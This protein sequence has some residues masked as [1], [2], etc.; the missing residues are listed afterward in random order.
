KRMRSDMNRSQGRKTERSRSLLSSSVRAISSVASTLRSAGASIASTVSVSEDDRRREQVQ[1]AGFD[2]LELQTGFSRRILLLA[3]TTG[4]QV[5]DIEEAYN[6]REVLS[7]R[8]GPVAFLRIQPQPITVDKEDSGF[9]AASPLLLVVT[10]DAAVNE[11]KVPGALGIGY[12]SSGGVSPQSENGSFMPTVVCFYSMKTHAYVHKLRFRSAIYSVR[13]SP[14]IIAVALTNQ[15]CCY[16]AATLHIMFNVLT[17]PTPQGGQGLANV[18]IGYGPMDVGPRWLAY[19]A[20]HAFVSN[21]G[22]ISP[23]SVSLL[24]APLNGSTVAHYAKE[25][26]KQIAAGIVTLGDMGYKTLTKYCSEFLPDSFSPPGSGIVNWKNVTDTSL[27]HD[28]ENAG[29]VIVRDFVSN[30]VV[31]QF[32]PHTS[33]I[34]ALCFDP[35][36]TLLVT[37]SIYGHNLNVFRIMPSASGTSSNVNASHIHVYKLVRGVTNAVIQDISF[38]DDSHSVAVSSS[39]GTSHLFSISPF[40]VVV[41]PHNHGSVLVDSSVGPPIVQGFSSM[42]PWSS[43]RLLKGNQQPLLPHPTTLSAVCKIRNGNDGWCSTISN[44]AATARGKLNVSP[45]AVAAV[46]HNGGN[47]C[48]ESQLGNSEIR[49]QLWGFS[50]PG[51]VVQYT[52]HPNAA[53][54]AVNYSN[55]PEVSAGSSGTR[56]TEDTRYEELQRW[57]VG[58]KSNMGEREDDVY[59]LSRAEGKKEGTASWAGYKN[60]GIVAQSGGSEQLVKTDIITEEKH[61]WYLSNAEVFTH[62]EGPVIWAKP[63]IYFHKIMVEASIEIDGHYEEAEI[64]KCPTRVVEIKSKD[65]MP[66]A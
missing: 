26:S 55:N 1:W 6:V 16:D 24:T 7:R 23:Q 34:S 63:E 57:D 44:A 66:L 60:G 42:C 33:P 5:W 22:R 51:H 56:Q 21:S 45:G 2:R 9:K 19:V 64:E 17:Y 8:D 37:A 39:R 50:P 40:S 47:Q 3:Y 59:E 32:K 38:S 61:C 65:L 43:S 48:L 13:C 25:S 11:G 27:G 4:F 49:N 41:A 20:T 10:G 35:S 29:T 52:F 53:V 18:N 54:D 46:F 30:V 14:R 31:A 62:Q 36:G 15:I 28:L 58:R 12:S